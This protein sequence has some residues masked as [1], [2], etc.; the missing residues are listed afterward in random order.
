MFI[1][2]RVIMSWGRNGSLFIV[3]LPILLVLIYGAGLS[4]VMPHHSLDTYQVVQTITPSTSSSPSSATFS[5]SF[6]NLPSKTLQESTGPTQD[7]SPAVSVA[8]YNEQ[9]AWNLLNCPG[10][11]PPTSLQYI[12][13][14]DVPNIAGNACLA[15][16]GSL[17][18][19]ATLTAQ[20]TYTPGSVATTSASLTFTNPVQGSIQLYSYSPQSGGDIS[21]AYGTDSYIFDQFPASL[22]HAIWGWY[23]EFADLGQLNQQNSQN[24]LT[25]TTSS[26]SLSYYTDTSGNPLS[27][28]SSSSSG[29]SSNDV[30]QYTY[31][32]SS[33]VTLESV[34][35]QYVPVPG[36]TIDSDD[37]A[38]STSSSSSGVDSDSDDD[39]ASAS[40][41]VNFPVLPYFVFNAN[42]TTPSLPAGTLNYSLSYDIYGPN[43]YDSVVQIDPFPIDAASLLY[44]S[45]QTQGESS[46]SLAAFGTENPAGFAIDTAFTNPIVYPFTPGGTAAGTASGC[47]NMAYTPYPT[48]GNPSATLTLQQVVD[49]AA[50]AGYSGTGLYTIVAIAY[51]ESSFQ[52]GVH[53]DNPDGR[54]IL[55]SDGTQQ[56][57]IPDSCAYNPTCIFDTEFQDGS[58]FTQWCTYIPSSCG[59]NG[60][61]SW[62]N[63]MPTTY[64]DPSLDCQQG[65]NEFPAATGNWNTVTIPSSIASSGTSGTIVTTASTGGP[66]GG[67]FNPVG[68]GCTF[69]RVDQGVDYDGPCNL[70]AIGPGTISSLTNSGW[71]Y[72]GA[73]AF[74]AI[75]LDNPLPAAD[76]AGTEADFDGY[77]TEWTAVNGVEEC[78][79][80]YYAE[81]ITQTP[82]LYVGEHVNACTVL[83]QALPVDYAIELGW[84]D[85]PPDSPGYALFHFLSQVSYIDAGNSG[86]TPPG[87]AYNSWISGLPSCP[88]AGSASGGSSSGGSS[89]GGSTGTSSASSSG[90]STES[91]IGTPLSITGTPNGFV[92]VL[93][94]TSS[95]SSSSSSSGSSSSSSSSGSSSGSGSSSSSGS[96][97]SS[98]TEIAAPFDSVD[99]PT[100]T[101][102]TYGI[103]CP[104]ATTVYA[105]YPGTVYNVGGD[106]NWG[107]VTYLR[108]NNGWTIGYAGMCTTSVADG[109]QVSAGAELGTAGCSIPGLQGSTGGVEFQIIT[110]YQGEPVAGAPAPSDSDYLNPTS[111]DAFIQGLFSN[112]EQT[113][114][115]TIA[116]GTM[117]P[118]VN[119]CTLWNNEV[120]NTNRATLPASVSTVCP[121]FA[122]GGLQQYPSVAGAFTQPQ[123]GSASSNVH[124]SV[125]DTVGIIE[126]R[127]PNMVVTATTPDSVSFTCSDASAAPCQELMNN[128][129][130][131]IMNSGYYTLLDQGIHNIDAPS[132]PATVDCDTAQ[133]YPGSGCLSVADG[134]WIP[135]SS[136]P[137]QGPPEV[138]TTTVWSEHE[139]DI[140]L[141]ICTPSE[142]SSS[143]G[144]DPTNLEQQLQSFMNTPDYVITGSTSSGGGAAVASSE[145]FSI[146]VYKQVNQGYYNT[147]LYQ[148]TTVQTVSSVGATS[149]PPPS[150]E[151]PQSTT[152][153]CGYDGSAV[154]CPAGDPQGSYGLATWTCASLG[155]IQC[156]D[157][158]DLPSSACHYGNLQGAVSYSCTTSQPT[159]GGPVIAPAAK[160]ALNTNVPPESFQ[161][162]STTTSGSTTT[163]TEDPQQ[164]W[165]S[166]WNTYWNN[167]Q[168]LQQG[169]TYLMATVS[170]QQILQ[171]IDTS[172]IKGHGN[173]GYIYSY[174][175]LNISTDDFGDIFLV[176]I[177]SE[178]H[179]A[180][181][182]NGAGNL[183]CYYDNGDTG[184]SGTCA[185][186]RSYPVITTITNPYSA[187]A[188][189]NSQIEYNLGTACNSLLGGSSDGNC[190]NTNPAVLQE[191]AASPTGTLVFLT[192]PKDA[193]GCIYTFSSSNLGFDNSF[194]L[195]YSVDLESAGVPNGVLG[196]I[197]TTAIPKLNI[198]SYLA[199]GGLYGILGN[200]QGTDSADG[201]MTQIM[202]RFVNMPGELD[203]GQNH[204][205]LAIQDVDGYLYVL[206]NW[207]GSIDGGS[208][209]FDTVVLRVMNSTGTDV[210][211]DPTKTNDVWYGSGSAQTQ[212]I[213]STLSP[214][215]YPPFGWILDANVSAQGQSVSLCSSTNN[216]Y[217]L[218]PSSYLG[219][220]YSGGYLPLGPALKASG[221]VQGIGMSV[222]ANGTVSILISRDGGAANKQY[223]EL[224]LSNF[225][226]QN[227][228]HQVGTSP[229]KLDYDCLIDTQSWA[230]ASPFNCQFNPDVASMS[231]ENQP[232]PIYFLAN[233]FRYMES[234]GS[235]QSL[236]YDEYFSSTLGGTTSV[237][238]SS[239]S[240]AG[241][242]IA[243]I[244]NNLASSASSA[245]SQTN[246]LS[247]AGVAALNTQIQSQIDGYIL[248]PYSYTYEVT[249]SITDQQASPNNPGACKPVTAITA[250]TA[251]TPATYTTYTYATY[252]L[253]SNLLPAT[254]EGGPSYVQYTDNSTYY[255]G[256]LS[257]ISVT[258]DILLNLFTDRVFSSL[259]TNMTLSSTSNLQNIANAIK[260]GTFAVVTAS[261]G[262][263][264]GYQTVQYTPSTSPCVGPTCAVLPSSALQN[265]LD[266]ANTYQYN[267]GDFQNVVA[268]FNFYKEFSITDSLYLQFKDASE[269]GSNQI[270]GYH[271]LI[272]V[273]KDR[274][275]NNIYMPI[276]ADIAN[277]TVI[278]LNVAP[279]V[280]QSNANSTVL[281]INGTANY[282]PYGSTTAIPLKNSLIYI[283]Y[284]KNINYLDHNPKSDPIAAQ[285]CAFGNQQTVA[286]V[287]NKVGTQVVSEQTN[288]NNLAQE[289]L[290]T[291]CQIADPLD[292]GQQ[293]LA[294]QVTYQ[295]SYNAMDECPPPPK[296]LLAPHSYDCNIYGYDGSTYI[297]DS[298]PLSSSGQQQFCSEVFANG[299]GY[300]TS[301]MGLIGTAQ[302]N[303]NGQFTLKTTACGYGNIAITAQYY[304]TPPP[305][306]ITADQAPLLDSANPNSQEAI[307]FP[308]NNY[309][310]LPTNATQIVP[311]GALL[312]SFGSLDAAAIIICIAIVALAW[313]ASLR[314]NK[315]ALKRNRPYRLPDYR[316]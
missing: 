50:A 240:T 93:M 260:E 112:A 103:Y 80:I 193:D 154:S 138:W 287:A 199:N 205:P 89:S 216:G 122:P 285:L 119:G 56:T 239:S 70:Y 221:Q 209:S 259:Y 41:G 303:A 7:A 245:E 181:G 223:G 213:P 29:S 90:Q 177:V 311:I 282:T 22:Q 225:N 19:T 20:P 137:A 152:C 58:A 64:S 200:G 156:G 43:D 183:N 247:A 274:F 105:V 284:N 212:Y 79:T 272:Y 59:G 226:I 281:T 23:A 9:N 52:P 315:R 3:S 162:T 151:A 108:L 6:S 308:V 130:E 129:V 12:Y 40:S 88:G 253:N 141:E 160:P 82:G 54:G 172:Q 262:S 91:Y 125:Y 211:I 81:G 87:L 312:L 159:C 184:C 288:L 229:P 136:S 316:R 157:L 8:N 190:C 17:S 313:Y 237:S 116:G 235:F 11:T 220:G 33:T 158:S 300:C 92:D 238:T 48:G 304:G 275:G 15:P 289:S 310:W 150:S 21:T 128:V 265:I 95:S 286:N 68:S 249:S 35:N 73:C 106:P 187:V 208:G 234:L 273:F 277:S 32:Y 243:G 207:Q 2:N 251:P 198:T 135:S 83:G 230:Q 142:S 49:C 75:N 45:Y 25:A 252:P 147:S 242:Q 222:S 189:I 71:C 132:N 292:S 283:Y 74:I 210:A 14:G 197:G 63:Y 307:T 1:F 143:C 66:S 233:P 36:A 164:Q 227:Y 266:F 254:V 261:Q 96:S 180:N 148:P 258:K 280:S 219:S 296:G 98:G 166:E 113:P 168:T 134:T 178:C 314:R 236:T 263:T 302:T 244:F 140:K 192:D 217:C 123:F 215:Y 271:R 67:Y 47:P 231:P 31:D 248:M 94:Q 102:N 195:T 55:Q 39:G 100:C 37:D 46:P 76:C 196:S 171:S 121:D 61:N 182:N 224:L 294:Q 218:D 201:T 145:Q 228:T 169:S 53:A 127:F 269:G 146:N 78:D 124:T 99:A 139:N 173:S 149:T 299:T 191:I 301:Q 34:Q 28:P 298:C 51:A 290:P 101:S 18:T 167:V 206:D 203:S 13:T 309:T 204:H 26:Q 86:A 120:I 42:V 279:Q 126:A 115:Q 114:S 72:S 30:C 60:D 179:T 268:L 293:A 202:S 27:T 175:P 257:S 133:G 264:P 170:S 109:Q 131:W 295:P 5:T 153:T 276:D 267:T 65:G 188:S 69:A 117:L 24:P 118:T 256:N 270:Y 165:N 291:N 186:E 297:Q 77:A 194:S 241:T 185:Y 38:A 250:L 16:S 161:P 246:P 44:T 305:E 57:S 107:T 4:A 111:V 110:S 155:Q 62:C 85:P 255:D 104:G 84:A 306:P 176:G 10:Q 144:F 174:T 214:T 97:G 163:S 278:E 232:H